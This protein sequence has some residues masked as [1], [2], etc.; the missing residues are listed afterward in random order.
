MTAIK[1]FKIFMVNKLKLSDIEFNVATLITKK[2]F[3]NY[4]RGNKSRPENVAFHY[5]Q[6]ARKLFHLL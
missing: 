2:V 4:K 1:I 5:G 3:Q 6:I